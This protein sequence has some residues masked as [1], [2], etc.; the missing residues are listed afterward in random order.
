MSEK[1]P[2]YPELSENGE[3]EAQLLIDRF[4]EKIRKILHDEVDEILGEIYCDVAFYIKSDSWS[5]F[6]NELMDG[7]S[8]YSNRRIQGEYDFKQIRQKIYEE[9]R[10]DIVKDLDQDNLEE[11]E[12]LKERIKWLEE[13]NKSRYY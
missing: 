10:E 3:I 13:V 1:Y 5:N 12:K 9:N 6:R 7:L 8:D 2:L 4:K 11:I